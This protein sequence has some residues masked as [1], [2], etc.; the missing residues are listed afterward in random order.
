MSVQTVNIAPPLSPLAKARPFGERLSSSSL[1]G[2]LDDYPLF[3]EVAPDLG[4]RA[5]AT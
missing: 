2:V 5:A 4:Y 1:F 3:H